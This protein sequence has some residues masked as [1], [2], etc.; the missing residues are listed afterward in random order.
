[1]IPSTFLRVSR[2]LGIGTLLLLSFLSPR[3]AVADAGE[4]FFETKIRPLL[5][6]HCHT[7]HGPTKQKGGLRL[8]SRA[9]ILKGGESGPAL[10]PDKPDE[11]RIIQAVRYNG[12]PQMPPKCKL[13][14][15]QIAALSAWVKMGAP[16]G[17]AA[18]EHRTREPQSVIRPSPSQHWSLAPIERPPLPQVRHAEWCRSPI[19]AFILAKLESKGLSPAAPAD[20]P[21]L[22]RRVTFDLIGLP[23][24]PEE[25]GAFL[26]DDSPDAFAK[27][28]ERLL[29]S[30]HYGERWGRH[31][32]DLVRYAETHGHEFDTD[33]Y[34][35]WRYR[36]YVIRAF[37][38][39]LPYDRFVTEQIA[40]DLLPQPR[41][42]PTER[43]N[44][45]V[46]ATGF[47]FLGEMAHSPVDVRKDQADRVDNQIDVFGKT[48]LGLTVSCARCHDHKFDPISQKDY[49]AL[50]GVLS[51]SRFERA[52][53]DDPA[54]VCDAVAKLQEVRSKWE[55]LAVGRVADCLHTA[56]TQPDAARRLI[57]CLPMSKEPT[58]TMRPQ[59][60]T[61]IL[62]ED[63]RTPGY[64]GWFVSGAAFGDGPT[65]VGEIIAR[66]DPGW[67]VARVLPSGVAHS[68]ATS[69]LLQGTLRS[70]TFRIEKDYIFF[71]V[72]G[73]ATKITVIVDGYQLI[74]E[75]I[76]GG[77]TIPI[78]HGDEF[79]WRAIN[80]AMWKGH[81][82]YIELLD[83]NAGYLAVEQIRF[84]DADCGP[85]QI[86]SPLLRKILADPE[87]ES[88]SKLSDKLRT[89]LGEIIGQWRD[90]KLVS[91]P[92]AAERIELLNRVLASKPLAEVNSI[93]AP[94]P[95]ELALFEILREQH[96]RL[97]TP[98]RA[99]T[100]CDGT[101]LNEH[102]FVRGNP[103]NV[104]EE[105]PRRFLHALP[106]GEQPFFA[107]G[108]GRM[109][110]ARRLTDPANPL[111]ARVM[112]NRVWQHH[113]GEGIVRSPDDFGKQGEQPTH[114]ELLDWLA[115][116]FVH[117]GWSVKHLHRLMVLSNAYQMDSKADARAEAADPQNKLL[118]HMPLRR[119]EAE[120]IRDALLAVSGRLDC[121]IGGPSVPP[122]LNP[123]MVGRGR[124]EH[125]GPLDGDGR[126]SIYLQVRR[127]FLNPM[128]VAFDYPT[129][130]TT[131][132]RRSVSNV[133]AQ[134]L[135]LMNNPFVVQQ[136]ELWATRILG[137]PL[138]TNAERV[139]GMYRAALGREPNELE[140]N[141]ALSFL[142]GQ[143]QEYG[144]PDDPRAWADLAHVLFNLK[145]FI[146]VR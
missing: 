124:P 60:D 16:W 120:A 84:S 110:L 103:K 7:C 57:E 48:F 20:K 17:K 127:N 18:D 40:G 113:F 88:P 9:A 100:I 125:S 1:M 140:L 114:P 146:F 68:G 51:S 31:W 63:F 117:S 134:A 75:P 105:V 78:N 133:P 47:W 8:D 66:T 96:G 2:C 69:P 44:E 30:P 27:V 97:P 104:G 141:D 25:V 15:D 89:L 61:G 95:E 29:A 11:S 93:P 111:T 14:D 83:D 72:A 10:F 86:L 71:R 145:E 91:L 139:A 144:K 58:A 130:F 85:Q 33:M 74:R 24:T 50:F 109:E 76:Y 53:I 62:F 26:G 37:N 59:Q 35:P 79:Q 45:S 135:A 126:R 41:R 143:A 42:H 138:R 80:V 38:D 81:S 99:S 73:R 49:Y 67:P 119:L 46:L 3:R 36:D 55:R 77:L 106:G 5:A 4:E 87:S 142:A 121:A 107:E 21:T 137:E 108:S 12:E 102:V 32:L 19:D 94:S 115:S 39:D 34:E 123:F 13:A 136:A 129:P 122:H 128:F 23:P 54:R 28:V 101:G 131:I 82:A 52:F 65:R 64:P 90:G 6:E 118:Q 132:G 22:I 92:D 98:R 43:W 56:L 70:K 112:A 116:E